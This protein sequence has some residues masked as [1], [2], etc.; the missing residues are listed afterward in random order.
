MCVHIH[1]CALTQASYLISMSLGVSIY[2]MGMISQSDLTG[3]ME[4]LNDLM[5]VTGLTDH[6]TQNIKTL[7]S[8]YHYCPW[9]VL[10][11]WHTDFRHCICKVHCAL[12]DMKYTVWSLISG[13]LPR[14]E[15]KKFMTQ[16]ETGDLDSIRKSPPESGTWIRKGTKCLQKGRE[17]WQLITISQV[18]E[19]F[20]KKLPK[21]LL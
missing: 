17:T 20:W 6:K 4:G 15:G 2:R 18:K 16:E 13:C 11:V 9:K 19:T 8:N 14:S 10:D 21:F 3:L 1:A 5:P 7:H 12:G